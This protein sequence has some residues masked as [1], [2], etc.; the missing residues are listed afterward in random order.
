MEIQKAFDE[1]KKI[2]SPEICRNVERIYRLETRHFQSSGFVKTYGAGM[3]AFS[4]T[5]PYGWTSLTKF[6]NGNKH[7]PNG[8]YI[9]PENKTGISKTF[10]TFPSLLS[11]LM[12]VAQVMKNRENNAGSWYSKNPDSQKSYNTKIS[13]ISVVYTS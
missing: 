4:R 8:F 1:L 13:N 12:A 6:W 7:A 2:Y 11:G 5:F 3:E 9:M 10:L